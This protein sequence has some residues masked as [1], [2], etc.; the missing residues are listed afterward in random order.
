MVFAGLGLGFIYLP[1]IVMVTTYFDK[2]RAFAT[3]IA[4]CGSGMGT[5][6]FAPLTEHLIAHHGWR[7]AM[8]I[9]AALVL[10]CIVFAA[11]FRPLKYKKEDKKPEEKGGKNSAGNNACEAYSDDVENNHVSAGH[12][13]DE[14]KDALLD[15]N[16]AVSAHAVEP[17][18]TY[19]IGQKWLYLLQEVLKSRYGVP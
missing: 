18:F 19:S 8:A 11:M 14:S 13:R 10:S 7:W 15:E 9:V 17:L 6:I 3:G 1:A 12:L 16:I 2:K 5:L 4:V